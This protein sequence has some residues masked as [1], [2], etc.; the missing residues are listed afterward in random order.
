MNNY[1]KALQNHGPFDTAKAQ[2]RLKSLYERI[3]RTTNPLVRLNLV[4]QH[5]DLSNEI[6]A[7]EGFAALEAEFTELI[8][9]YASAKGLGYRAL[10]EAGV[11]VKVLTEAGIV[12][13][14]LPR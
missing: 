2:A 5:L 7:H 14:L 4:Q 3:G 10:R 11:P 8:A 6:K 1:L 9:A 12:R 13:E